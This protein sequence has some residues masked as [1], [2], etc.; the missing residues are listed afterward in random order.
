MSLTGMVGLVTGGLGG[1]GS[2]TCIAMAAAGATV[3]CADLADPATGDAHVAGL[4][5]GNGTITYRTL[6]VTDETSV[7]QVVDDAWTAFGAVDLLVN[8]AGISGPPTPTHETT[9]ADFDRI[10]AVNVKGTWLCTK[11]VIRRLLDADRPGS[12]VN[13]SSIN[14][15][16]ASRLVPATYHATKGA[17]RLMA[18]ADALHYG[19][20]GIRVNSVHPGSVTTPLA[21]SAAR[22]HPD[23]ED[24]Y[25]ARVLANIPLG[26]RAEPREI[27]DAV[28]YLLSPAAAFVTGA[29]LVV[30]GGFTAH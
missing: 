18:K 19:A 6:D 12:I 20:A 5:S 3:V 29:E 22:A 9:E 1:I 14:G 30:D 28:V 4:P 2:A 26:R 27:A 25:T 17:V 7:Q 8:N 11:H 13:V 16:V 15:L 23:G 10:M 21:L 24:A